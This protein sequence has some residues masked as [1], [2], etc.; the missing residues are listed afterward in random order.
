MAVVEKRVKAGRTVTVLQGQRRTGRKGPREKRENGTTPAQKEGNLRRATQMLGWLMAE[1]FKDGDLLVTLDYKEN[2]PEGSDRMQ[3][4]FKNFYDRL[5]RRLKKAGLPP[6]KYIRVMD[7]GK[8]G[9]RHHHLIMQETDLKLLR[10]CWPEGGIDVDPLYT[11][12]NYRNIAEYFVKYAKKTMEAE[13]KETKKLCIPSRGLKKPTIGKP[14]LIKSRELGRLESPKGIIWTR[15]VCAGVSAAM[16]GTRP[17]V[18]CL[19]CCP[20]TAGSGRREGNAVESN[21]QVNL[22]IETTVHGPRQQGG[23]WMYLLEFVT[24]RGD[25]VTLWKVGTGRRRRKTC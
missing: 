4:D 23:R 19:L 13:E 11:D 5:K 6:P 16:T 17:F 10:E 2:R 7:V 24:R 3:K 15:T 12:G 1:N 8:K 14:K 9:A 18:I 22:Y 20:D 21:P 25:P